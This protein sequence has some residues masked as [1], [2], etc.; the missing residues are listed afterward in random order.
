M[1]FPASRSGRSL[2]LK[3]N[4]LERRTLGSLGAILLLGA[5]GSD[6]VDT[7]AV[8]SLV[9]GGRVSSAQ[10]SVVRAAPGSVRSVSLREIGVGVAG[11]GTRTTDLWVH[12]GLALTGS[13]GSGGICSDGQLCG[14]PVVVWDVVDPTR[15]VVVDTI[16]TAAPQV[17]D[18]KISADGRFAVATKEGAGQ[19]I[20]L[21]AGS[22]DGGVSVVTEFG[23]GLE[24]GV[25]NTWIESIGGRDYVFA[26]ED[27]SSAEGGLHVIDV[28]D[29]CAPVEV[30]S[31]YA[32]SS[33]VH[34]V[35]V[36]D[37]LAFVSHW[38]LGLVI[39]DVGNGVVGGSPATP[40]EVSRIELPGG[41]THNAWF[42]PAA[43]YV[44]V[45]QERVLDVG[46][47]PV[48]AGRVTVIDV[49]DLT[50]PR[51]V[52]TFTKPGSTPPHNFWLDETRGIL[53]VAWYS[54]G[55]VAIDVAG[56]LSGELADEGREVALA[57]PAGL[58]N[59][60]APQIEGGVVYASDILT[61]IRVFELLVN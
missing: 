17:G 14:S 6:P 52:A 7:C 56:E 20:V 57:R 24:N 49:R 13:S 18:V 36:R 1:V 4:P 11:F 22:G 12:G 51:I 19:G 43:G 31:F 9:P 60:W 28:T 45:G 39:L 23:V 40:I 61:G 27:G 37:G 53:L 8:E 55:L 32:G 47:P 5:C 10:R 41:A 15:P 38:D 21:L 16:G 30:S 48:P 44:F 29:L 58:F 25:H 42:W 59:F 33:S 34:D 3:R 54:V 46:N 2:R 26:A 35:L 50:A